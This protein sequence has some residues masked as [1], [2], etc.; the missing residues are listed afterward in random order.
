[1]GFQWENFSNELFLLV[2]LVWYESIWKK[3]YRIKKGILSKTKVKQ[4]KMNLVIKFHIGL[5][6]Y[7]LLCEAARIFGELFMFWGC[8]WY[9]YKLGDLTIEV[10][11]NYKAHVKCRKLKN[12]QVT[13][14]K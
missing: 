12:K 9:T 4:K 3:E 14:R 8:F 11:S 13:V 5:L 6:F 2:F 1:M 10:Y 7:G